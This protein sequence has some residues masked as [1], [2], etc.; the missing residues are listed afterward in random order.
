MAPLP[1]AACY[2]FSRLEVGLAAAAPPPATAQQT[3]DGRMMCTRGPN[4]L[5]FSQDTSRSSQYHWAGVCKKACTDVVR[6]FGVRATGA[7]GTGTG[8]VTGVT[9]PSAE[10]LAHYLAYVV[11]QLDL[12]GAFHVADVPPRADRGSEAPRQA[13]EGNGAEGKSAEGARRLRAAPRPYFLNGGTSCPADWYFKF[14]NAGINGVKCL[15]V[16]IDGRCLVA[17][18]D[19]TRKPAADVQPGDMVAAGR[20]TGAGRGA[21]LA[22]RVECT[23]H[24]HCGGAPVPM[25]RVARGC[26]LTPEHPFRGRG[27][28]GAQG[29]AEA[30]PSEWRVPE[31]T[32]ATE[33]LAVATLC[34]FVLEEGAWCVVVDGVECITL[35]HG[36][37]DPRVR[38]PTWGTRAIRRYLESR[39]GYPAVTITGALDERL[40]QSFLRD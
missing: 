37:A 15:R 7:A 33:M 35:G 28:A 6:A 24:Q 21:R 9:V 26:Y 29:A 27:P 13:A 3:A 40:V 11:R 34:N 22:A 14:V 20:A 8:G 30:G 36:L 2:L 25:C 17:M 16:C 18:A 39:P 38:H 32:V 4:L 5:E 23:T 19:G 12:D 31:N 10:Q 1:S